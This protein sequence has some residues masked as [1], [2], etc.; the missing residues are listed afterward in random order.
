MGL[1]VLDV[2][3]RIEKAFQI[4]LRKDDLMGLV[5]DQDI[6]VG[7]LYELVLKKMHLRDVGRYDIRLNQQLWKGMQFV[8]HAATG[9]PLNEI[10]LSVPLETLFPRPTRRMTWDALRAACPYRVLELDYPPHPRSGHGMNLGGRGSCRAGIADNAYLLFTA[11]QEPRPPVFSQ[12][13]GA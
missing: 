11:R 5:R 13:L 7:D 2:T 9:T 8:L 6:T 12:T 1:D 10:Q 3:F 4:E